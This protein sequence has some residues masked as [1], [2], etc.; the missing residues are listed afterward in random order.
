[1]A[2]LF[3]KKVWWQDQDCCGM[4]EGVVGRRLAPVETIFEGSTFKCLDRDKK[5][6]QHKQHKQDKPYWAKLGKLIF[7]PLFRAPA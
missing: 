4:T 6:K 3:W 7:C 5:D 1:M 2:R